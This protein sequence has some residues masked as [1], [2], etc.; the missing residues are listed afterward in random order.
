MKTAG[1]A[2]AV[3]LLA[4]VGASCAC[5]GADGDVAVPRMRAWPR[6]ALYP[7]AYRAE[8]L[9]FGPDSIAVNASATVERISPEWFN[10]VYPA[11]GITVNCTLTAVRPSDASTVVAN[12]LERMARNLGDHRADIARS[13]QMTLI[14]APSALHTPVQFLAT[15]SA[16]YVLSGVAVTSLA[17]NAPADSVAPVIDAIALDIT[18][19]IQPTSPS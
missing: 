9:P 10:I 8:P 16:T 14:V 2:I 18:R 17:A 3:M 12:R 4:L 6:P 13:G 1:T 19:M 7:A 5:T 15:D 11:Y